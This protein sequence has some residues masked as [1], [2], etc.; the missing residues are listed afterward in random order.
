MKLQAVLA[1]RKVVKVEG[2]TGIGGSLREK[3]GSIS[4]QGNADLRNGSA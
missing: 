1:G 3:L 4:E 2:S